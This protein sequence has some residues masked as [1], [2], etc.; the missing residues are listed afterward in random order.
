M[1]E[2]NEICFTAGLCKETLVQEGAQKI[3]TDPR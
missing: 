3:Q 1:Q 2:Q